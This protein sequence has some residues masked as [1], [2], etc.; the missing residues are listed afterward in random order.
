[1]GGFEATAAIR[2]HETQTGAHMPVIAMTAHALK[3]DQERCLAAGMDDY[4]TKPLDVAKLRTL[5]RQ[6]AEKLTAP[7]ERA[8]GP[9]A[10]LAVATPGSPPDRPPPGESPLDI[11]EALQRLGGDRELLD[12][13]LALLVAEIPKRLS[14]FRAAAAAQ[15]VAALRMLAHTLKG[16]TANLG[17]QPARRAAEQ[18]E[19]LCGQGPVLAI[20]GPLAD[21]E[22]ELLRLSAHVATLKHE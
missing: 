11:G 17:A 2:R 7:A 15:N 22:R 3:G 1:M 13:M 18:L 9:A 16:A 4:L 10:S 19:E 6:W 14:E 20:E 12:E 21:L 5:L 8:S